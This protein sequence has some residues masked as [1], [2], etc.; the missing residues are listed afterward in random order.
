VENITDDIELLAPVGSM[1]SLFAAVENGADAVYL[2]GKLFNARQ[3]ADNFSLEEL[4]KVVEYAH[5]RN[6][7]VYITVNILI[8][9]EEVE[10]T[11]NYVKYL[12]EIDVDGLI[13][14]DIGLAYAIRKIFPDF[15][16]HASTQ[17]TINNLAGTIF[18]E[19]LGF[20]K[21]VLSRELSLREIK[22]IKE[23]SNIPL[24]CFIHG[25]LCISYSGQ[26]LMSSIIGGR[27][28]NRGKCAQPCRMPYTLVNYKDDTIVS[29][30]FSK[31]YLLSPKDLNTIKDIDKLIDS[32][33]SSLKIEG[34]MKRPEYVATIVSKY[35]KV[36]DYGVESITKEDRN[37]M[38]Q[39]FNRGF[40][41]GYILDDYGKDMISFYRPDNRGIYVGKVKKI[42]RNNM[43]LLLSEDIREG[44]GLE[45]ELENGKYKGLIVE[46]SLEKGKDVKLNIIN[47]VRKGSN[48]FKSS[49]K[50]LLENARKSYEDRQKIYGISM[51][52][53]IAK[54]KPAKL[55]AR[56]K[57]CEV[58]VLS[59]EN[60]EE[61]IK[62]PLSEKRIREQ[63]NKLAD[64]PY[65]LENVEIDLE[66]DCFLPISQVNLL[67]RK[68]MDE[69]N[70]KRSNFNHREP[71]NEEIFS[72]KRNN[73][74]K[75]NRKSNFGTRKIN[76]KVVTMEQFKQ[77]NLKKLNRV[78]LEYF[79]GI[80]DAIKEVKSH[81]KEV[82]LWTNKI[83]SDQ[84]LLALKERVK[85]ME[86][87]LDGISVSNLGTLNFAL[88]HFNLNIHGDTGLNIFNSLSTSFLNEQGLKSITLSPEL[89]L[90]QIRKIS[91]NNMLPIETLGYGYLPLMIMKH[92]PMSLIKNCKDNKACSNCNLKEGYGLKDRKN[93]IFYIKRKDKNTILYNCVPLI[94]LEELD[95]VFDSGVNMIRLDFT[96]ENR[97]I[98]RIQEIFYDYA[99]GA[100]SRN[101]VNKL[102]KEFKMNKEL[103]KGHYFRGVL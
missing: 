77:L 52:V 39:I 29:E 32:G 82:Y 8:D 21:V 99:V 33:I 35:R 7:K 42:D 95:K 20:K 54:G 43:Y 78:Y 31:K 74:I 88:E 59:D 81:G 10:E 50:S 15:N 64:T 75:F 30:E 66:E 47:G 55:I 34:R 14:Q 61:A 103:T 38:L 62:V 67:R 51:K 91:N 89:N 6:V 46:N 80:E 11:L 18:L 57:N 41:K 79:E 26:C 83:L 3:F 44:D 87:D 48:V 4:K 85:P 37:R 40:T 25:A 28:G 63:L 97:N 9:N 49:N 98:R 86:K 1:E 101:D 12:Y 60:V 71:V 19:E 76:V 72:R 93:K 73:L 16:L 100:I 23:N 45:F 69:L 5:L 56:E 27:S 65:V 58:K 92:C 84:D 90:N 17:M 13:V 102:I 24:E 70:K 22:Y 53:S 2:G 96:F 36:L 94:I 68:A